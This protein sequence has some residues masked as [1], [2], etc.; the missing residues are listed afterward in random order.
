MPHTTQTESAGQQDAAFMQIALDQARQAA[1][2]GEV[3]V[4]AV[5]VK[6]GRVIGV[7]RNGPIQSCDPSAHAEIM[8]LRAAALALGN[9][10]LD[11]CTL[12]VTL[13][14]CAMCSGA[15]LHSRVKRLV[16]GA[17]DP[18]TGCAGSVL[19]LFANATLN[20]QTQVDGG[21]LADQAGQLLAD[22]F[23]HK[24]VLQRA[25]ATP[26]REDALRT[27][28]RCFAD[29]P[30]YPWPPNYVSD[31]PSL[32]GLRLHYLDEGAADSPAVHLFL[33][34]VPGWS[35]SQRAQILALLGQG[36]RVVAPDLIGFGK[37]DKP[38]R[39]DFHSAEFHLQ[40]VL[41]L[42]ERLDLKHITLVAP[43][44]THW[45][46]Q[47]LLSRAP[48]RFLRLQRQPAAPLIETAARQAGCD[49][50]YPDAGHR[51]ALRAFAAHKWH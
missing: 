36:A 23:K 50:P 3:P 11:D 49:A 27:P 40:C 6:A 8:A 34:P 32:A 25:S 19:N 29:L 4:G 51:A 42:V 17:D 46:A 15:V 21:L 20:H 1:A 30:G 26:V 24:R 13:E 5:V 38:K 18:K 39:E 48:H 7:G 16:F 10:R 9:Y 43:K 14:P 35:Y 37:S 44:D 2:A 28:E 47:L 45:L 33:H 22:F 41:E 31:L 12:Y